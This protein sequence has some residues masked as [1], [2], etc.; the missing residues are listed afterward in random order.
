VQTKI[1][2]KV[3]GYVEASGRKIL[4]SSVKVVMPTP[5]EILQLM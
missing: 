1:S 3:K 4:V 2:I 5:L